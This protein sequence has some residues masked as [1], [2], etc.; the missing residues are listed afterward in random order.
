MSIEAKS[1]RRRAVRTYVAAVA[2]L[3]D[4]DIRLGDY[5]V[6]DL[7]AGGALLIGAGEL[8]RGRRC[9]VLLQVAGLGH[10][11]VD[12]EVAHSA[13]AAS[14]A[15]ALGLKFQQLSAEVRDGL[16]QLVLQELERATTP[17]VLV[18]DTNIPRLAAV[19]EALAALGERPL[20]ARTPLEVIQR[21]SSQ[22]TELSAVFVGGPAQADRNALL[23]DFVR[24]EFPDLRCFSLEGSVD[25]EQL[26]EL[27][28][29]YDANVEL[30]VPPPREST[31][32]AAERR[33]S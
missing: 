14:G 27:L 7:S 4:G 26:R 13:Q 29:G 32:P 30:N 10:L 15:V 1:E 33:L 18:V 31:F 3:F 24:E 11:R 16:Q 17:A 9:R 12:A 5:F 6:H 25:E 21:L 28:D 23:L 20:L 22:E 19:A 2:T 8:A